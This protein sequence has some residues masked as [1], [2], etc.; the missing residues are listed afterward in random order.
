MV[1]FASLTLGW[2]RHEVNCARER[3]LARATIRRSGGETSEDA[4]L[5]VEYLAYVTS[6]RLKSGSE[7]KAAA[8][9]PGLTVLTVEQATDNDLRQLKAFTRLRWLYLPCSRV[10]DRGLMDL[11]ELTALR[12]LDILSESVTDHGLGYLA[13]LR[14]LE[15]LHLGTLQVTDSGLDQLAPLKSLRLLMLVGGSKVTSAGLARLSKSLPTC[16]FCEARDCT[17]PGAIKPDVFVY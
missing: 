2:L 1:T 14:S 11:A 4:V 17:K 7:L 12:G 16:I 15:S 8:V 9:F 5:S 13:R 6:A 3:R 10:T